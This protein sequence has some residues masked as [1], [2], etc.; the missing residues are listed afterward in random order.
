M[1]N[2]EKSRL[3]NLGELEQLVMDHVWSHGTT[4][5]ETCRAALLPKHVIKDS[6]VRTVLRRLEEKGFVSHTF[7]SVSR[8][9]VTERNI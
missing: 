6:T 9:N 5:A 7:N 4:T 2:N 8:C 3:R 1:T